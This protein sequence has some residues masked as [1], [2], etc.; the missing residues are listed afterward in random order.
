MKIAFEICKQRIRNQFRKCP[1]TC[2]PGVSLRKLSVLFLKEWV[3]YSS[4][5]VFGI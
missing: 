2:M 1:G 5:I 4:D 3:D